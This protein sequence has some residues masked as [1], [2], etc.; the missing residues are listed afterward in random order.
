MKKPSVLMF[1]GSP[2][3]GGNSD[4]L[5]DFFLSGA[6]EAGATVERVRL[7]KRDIGPCIEC[8][9]CDTTGECVLED[10]MVSIYPMIQQADIVVVS[11]P[12]FFYNITSRT[13]A[14]VERSQ[15]LWVRKYVLK[16]RATEGKARQGVFLSVGA[17]KG[18][19][20]FDGVKRVLR[21]FFDALDADFVAGLFIR[22]VEKR[23]EIKS[24]PYA[25]ERARQLGH[26]LVTGQGLSS[27]E[28]VWL[29]GKK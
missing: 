10:D 1:Y 29:P 4:L 21:Y 19:L 23:A 26:A 12:I 13:Q 16:K 27:L 9:G 28:D 25:L 7:Y 22:G 24:H 18:R 2:R 6:E 3:R 11:S 15:A 17:T 5:G 14:L 20:L 8:G